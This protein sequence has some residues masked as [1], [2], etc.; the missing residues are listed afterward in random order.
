M[1]SCFP[2]SITSMSF[3]GSL[4][5]S[6]MLPASFAAWGTVRTTRLRERGRVVR[7]VPH[8]GDEPPGA[9]LPAYVFELVLWPGFGDEVV[10]ACIAGYRP[11][12]ERVIARNHDDPEPHCAEPGDTVPYPQLEHVGE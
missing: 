4:S 11:G 2:I 1:R 12:S 10:Q 6:T 8:H 9:L 3:V 7:T 5:R